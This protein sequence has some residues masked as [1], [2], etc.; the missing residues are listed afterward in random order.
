MK[1]VHVLAI[2]IYSLTKEKRPLWLNFFISWRLKYWFASKPLGFRDTQR[3]W[4][5]NFTVPT[6]QITNEVNKI[7]TS[8]FYFHNYW[9][10]QNWQCRNTWLVLGAV[11]DKSETTWCRYVMLFPLLSLLKC[12]C[13]NIIFRWRMMLFWGKKWKEVHILSLPYLILILNC[14]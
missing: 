2:N 1:K 10:Y 8:I 6:I 11:I 7:S 3:Y 12:G 9:K 13:Y 14:V 5:G 4:V